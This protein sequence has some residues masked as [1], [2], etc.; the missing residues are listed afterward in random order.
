MVQDCSFYQ[1]ARKKLRRRVCL[2]FYSVKQNKSKKVVEVYVDPI[3][4][5]H[6]NFLP[7]LYAVCAV[8]FVQLVRVKV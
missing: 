6:F 2:F 8:G 5:P 7:D 3:A 1:R 4:K